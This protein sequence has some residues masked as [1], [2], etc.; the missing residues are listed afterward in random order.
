[1]QP[2]SLEKRVGI[3]ERTMEALHELPAR[4]EALEG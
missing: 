1:M 3:L 4:V 2:D